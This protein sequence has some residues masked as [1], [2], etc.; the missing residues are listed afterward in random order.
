M[1][2]TG[3]DPPGVPVLRGK[4]HAA[5][6]HTLPGALPVMSQTRMTSPFL[7]SLRFSFLALLLSKTFSFLLLSKEFGISGGSLNGAG[8]L[9]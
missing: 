5:V 4:S 1:V 8:M 7:G 6:V 2:E 3:G 9:P